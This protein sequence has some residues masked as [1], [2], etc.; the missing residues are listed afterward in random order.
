MDKVEELQEELKVLKNEIKETLADVREHLLTN[1]D[2]PFSTGA[3]DDGAS[4][5][6]A[7]PPPPATPA[8]TPE[9]ET[10]QNQAPTP[11][12]APAQPAAPA[13]VAGAA[14][15][16]MP[17]VISVPSMGA[18]G[19]PVIGGGVIGG[20]V[21]GPMMGP[22]SAGFAPDIPSGPPTSGP[23]VAAPR[24]TAGPPPAR[25]KADNTLGESPAGGAS[26]NGAGS[27]GSPAFSP[28][29]KQGTDGRVRKAPSGRR[30]M[31]GEGNNGHHVVDD[32]E[33]YTYGEYDDQDEAEAML[34]EEDAKPA[35]PK[36]E[37][38]L[39][40][41]ATLAPWMEEG[42]RKIGRKRLKT[43]LEVYA[44]MDGISQ[45][46]KEVLLQLVGMDD[47]TDSVKGKVSL[48]ECMR[49]L[50]DLDEI[51]WRGRQDWKRAALLSM[52]ADDRMPSLHE[53]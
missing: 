6:A 13:P 50:V 39:V 49:F 51:L 3:G 36:D 27:M 26:G 45:G 18:M 42:V 46:F 12:P 30:P 43:V 53:D 25:A 40:T 7:A 16:A 14:P 5:K 19:M 52:F 47:A 10:A 28:E 9:P 37:F 31:S 15:P 17:Q 35:R 11:T 2:N 48:R 33:A 8:P 34:Y 32:P 41:L 24:P 38:D 21:A 44:S 20:A 23:P 22:A 29:H 1:V 4:P